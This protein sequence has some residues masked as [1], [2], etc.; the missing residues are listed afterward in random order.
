MVNEYFNIFDQNMEYI[1][2]NLGEITHLTDEQRKAVIDK[3]EVVKEF[4]GKVKAE[5]DTKPQTEDS[6]F[7]I[8]DI[9]NKVQLLKVECKAIFSAPP[10]KPKE[11]ETKEGEK[12][13]D[14]E[15][16]PADGAEAK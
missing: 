2:K 5:L 14:W 4:L 6:S 16:V 7:T 9:E 12:D 3:T 8:P 13:G 15:D 11:P 10:Q 1:N